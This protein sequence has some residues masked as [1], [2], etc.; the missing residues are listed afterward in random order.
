MLISVW[1]LFYA[2]S[3]AVIV[4]GWTESAALEGVVYVI[5]I[6]G[7]AVLPG[8]CVHLVSRL[9]GNTASGAILEIT[10]HLMLTLMSCALL[11]GWGLVLA[12]KYMG[13]GAAPVWVRIYIL[14]TL[15][16]G[17]GVA[18]FAM[19]APDKFVQLPTVEKAGYIPAVWPP[20]YN[21]PMSVLR[22]VLTIITMF[23]PWVRIRMESS[24]SHSV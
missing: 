5:T 19:L 18:I 20:M 14:A 22:I 23:L 11:T 1:S 21:I 4:F 17:F 8:L 10:C 7:E 13:T 2:A 15:I 6:A 3:L 9:N 24:H 16:A 12:Y